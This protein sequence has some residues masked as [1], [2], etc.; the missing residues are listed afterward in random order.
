[1]F[2]MTR[3]SI[4]NHNL[5]GLIKVNDLK[6]NIRAVARTHVVYCKIMVTLIDKDTG[7][8]EEL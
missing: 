6:V 7:K 1:M 3:F 8:P 2:N 4:I 5:L